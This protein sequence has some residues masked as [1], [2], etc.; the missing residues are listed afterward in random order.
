MNELEGQDLGSASHNNSQA[1]EYMPCP[2][3]G[4]L[5]YFCEKPLN[6]KTANRDKLLE[7][8]PA[9]LTHGALPLFYLTQF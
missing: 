4:K 7:F 2:E 5:Y 9:K 3:L 1:P 8:T 6:Y